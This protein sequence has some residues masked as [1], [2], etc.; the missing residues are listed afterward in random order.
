MRRTFSVP[1]DRSFIQMT[2]V[3][4]A[5]L[6]RAWVARYE[7]LYVA[8]WWMPRGY[9]NSIV[10]I[11][12]APQGQWRMCQR[13]P[14]GNEFSF[15]GHFTVVEPQVRTVQTY[16]SELF[17]DV[18][19]YLTTEFSEVARGTQIVTHHAFGDMSQRHGYLQLGGVERMAEASQH[20]DRLL[21]KLALGR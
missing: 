12:L 4:S 8:Q 5:P 16:V 18:E 19:T 9:V 3:V 14:E 11:D 15:Y 1:T 13:D 17:P 6:E 10:D 7:P 2:E 20:Y 21:S